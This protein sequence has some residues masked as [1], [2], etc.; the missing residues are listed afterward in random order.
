[1]PY[2]LFYLSLTF[3]CLFYSGPRTRRYSDFLFLIT[4]FCIGN[5]SP[6]RP[7]FQP[8]PNNVY[9][10]QG[11]CEE[12]LPHNHY[13]L[14]A[15]HN[16]FYL[17][18]QYLTTT[19]QPGDSLS[20]YTHISSVP[21]ASNPGE[22][23]YAQYLKQKNVY[24]QLLPRTE[25]VQYNS[26]RHLPFLFERLRKT[27]ITKTEKLTQDSV[28]YR[29]MQAL[30][31]GYKNNMDNQI[32]DLFIRTG[33]I[34]LLAV[35]GLH[36]GAIYLFLLFIFRHTGFYG[37]KK[38]LC[39]LPLLW[40]YACLTG[41]SPSV[42]RAAIILSFI[43]LGRAFNK[44]YI[45]LNALAASAFFTLLLQPYLLK[46]V[47]F[48]LSY[49]AYTGI[50]I[51]YPF[52]YRLPGKLSPAL[53]KL[54]ASCCISIA[55]QLPTLPIVA[56][57]FHTITINS[58]LINI[59]AIPLATLFLYSSAICMILPVALSQ[60]LMILPEML[61]HLLLS[62]LKLFS[63]FILN[64]NKL[65]PQPTFVFL[66]YIIFICFFYLFSQRK[67]TGMI[68]S[69]ISLTTLLT[70]QIFLNIHLSRQKEILIFHTYRQSSILLNY[71]GFYSILVNS[72]PTENLLTP[73][74]LSHKLKP[75][76]PHNGFLNSSLLLYHSTLQTTHD[77]IHIITTE[78][79]DYSPCHTLIITGNVIPER[80]FSSIPTSLYP[81]AILL[82]GSNHKFISKK[83]E[84]FS[85]ENQISFRTTTAEGCIRL[86][87]K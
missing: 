30:C 24:Y 38:E 53:S 11:R 41:L 28:C 75:L 20:F 59:L 79:M 34:H 54:Y 85:R 44:N 7:S 3:S 39:I 86:N 22:F 78:Y 14:S 29:L 81:K 71:E 8:E 57:Y 19:C 45:P 73:F 21:K 82:D 74:I 64:I 32:Q 50:L 17:N 47:S 52:L 15:A 1:M 68:L 42:V 58:F 4:I 63:P 76:P 33:T 60:Y 69:L 36:T 56:Y 80:V 25:I 70:Y 66:V 77:T 51:I 18:R 6:T 72:M 84:E 83:W 16:R 62:L 67:K 12:L 2:S 26:S 40:A 87:L 23:D 37:P 35:S 5:A 49:S 48:L 55:A 9:Y 13:I 27:C 61:S 31:L 43:T 65:Y 46:S 10:F